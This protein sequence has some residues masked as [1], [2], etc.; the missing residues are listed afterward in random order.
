MKW[1]LERAGTREQMIDKEDLRDQIFSH[2]VSGR[3]L[4]MLHVLLD[5]MFLY[6]T[7]ILHHTTNITAFTRLRFSFHSQGE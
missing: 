6:F 5:R 4:P 2:R 7:F 3:D 1:H